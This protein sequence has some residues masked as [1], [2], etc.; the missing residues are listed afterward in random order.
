LKIFL[1]III[2][3]TF[4]VT[5]GSSAPSQSIIIEVTVQNIQLPQGSIA[6]NSGASY[7][8]SASVTLSLTAHDYQGNPVSQMQ[9]SNNNSTWSTPEDFAT[10]KAWILATGDGAKTVYVK[11]KDTIG[12]WST[13]YSSSII[14][15]TTAPQAGNIT[16]LPLSANPGQLV[17]FTTTYT[18][19]AGTNAISSVYLLVN[20][21]VNGLNCLYGYYNQIENK[22]YL[23]N[24]SDTAW[25]GGF[26]PGSGNFIENAYVKLDCSDS[27]VSGSGTTLTVTW[28]LNFK[29]AFAG[30]KDTYL[31]VQ[32][33]TNLNSGWIK[34]GDFC[35]FRSP[36]QLP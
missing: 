20:N 22:F 3:L 17:T 33:Q 30:V 4:F 2:F 9:F 16:V 12:N 23:R 26:S 6:I 25:L 10:T 1:I 31:Y 15:D 36:I 35:I 7:T 5:V 18:D 21:A 27:T 32:D 8:N 34:K 28:S 13:A 29:L 11:F 19:L 14:L 24:D